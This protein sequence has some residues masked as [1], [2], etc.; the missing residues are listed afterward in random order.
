MIL[1]GLEELD[2]VWVV[3]HLHD[4][5]KGG[6]FKGTTPWF[7]WLPLPPQLLWPSCILTTSWGKLRGQA[8]SCRSNDQSR[9]NYAIAKELKS[10][11]ADMSNKR[12]KKEGEEGKLLGQTVKPSNPGNTPLRCWCTLKPEFHPAPSLSE[13]NKRKQRKQQ[14]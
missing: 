13:A 2:D 6:S 9:W 11:I 8:E 1:K 5:L 10:V 7:S 3:H 14:Q 4:G 12:E